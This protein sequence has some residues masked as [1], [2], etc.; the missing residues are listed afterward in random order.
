MFRRYCVFNLSIVLSEVRAE[1][2]EAFDCMNVTLSVTDWKSP[3]LGDADLC[4][5]AVCC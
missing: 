4:S 1:A 3:R 5:I 2:E